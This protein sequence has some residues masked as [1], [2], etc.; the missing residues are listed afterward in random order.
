ML[1]LSGLNKPQLQAVKHGDTPLMV[2]AG[3]GAGK[4]RVLTHRV[5][6][7]IKK[8][9]H[10][11]S[12]LFVS[13]FTNAAAEEMS[14]RLSKMIGQHS[15]DRLRIGTFHSLCR[16]ILFDCLEETDDNFEA[17][18]LLRGG[19]RFFTMQGLIRSNKL[20]GIHAK[21][22]LKLIGLWKNR[23]V[24]VKDLLA[25][26]GTYVPVAVRAYQL[27]QEHL[28]EANAYDFDDMLFRTYWVL[29][30]KRSK[31]F[32]EKLRSRIDHILLDEAQD[33]A[34]IQYMIMRL[35]SEG[36]RH[37]TV[38]GD[39]WQAIFGFRGADVESVFGFVKEYSATIV[40]LEENYRSTQVIVAASNRLIKHNLKQLPKTLFTSN[41]AGKPIEIIVGH[42]A[43]DEAENVFNRINSLLV[44][45]GYELKDIAILYRTNAQ[46]RAIVDILIRNCIPHRV[47][48]NYGFYDRAEVKDMVSYL[49][50][51]TNPNDA[52]I[53]DFR[54][55]INKPTRYLGKKFIDQVESLQIDNDMPT[56]WEAFQHV[57]DLDIGPFQRQHAVELVRV[58][59]TV[60]QWIVDAQPNTGEIFQRV[61]T[62][63]KYEAWLKKEDS[64]E[65][66][67]DDSKELNIESLLA[68]AAR[69]P[70]AEDFLRFIDSIGDAYDEGDDYISLMSCHKAKGQE[71][72]VV[73]VLGVS[74]KL[75]PH[76]KAEDHDEERR[77]FFVA[78]TRPMECLIISAIQGKYNRLNVSPSRYIREM[79]LVI[80]ETFG[81]GQT[82]N[83]TPPCAEPQ[84]QQF[85]LQMGNAKLLDTKGDEIVL[86]PFPGSH[87]AELLESH[88]D[89]LLDEPGPAVTMGDL[90]NI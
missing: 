84:Q 24:R 43:D 19:G 33:T 17:P 10:L 5:A 83:Y 62:E 81:D 77:V 18:T 25:K 31:K 2:S 70:S 20:E 9:G 49:R 6:Y 73:F 75:M 88:S 67:P 30:K 55:I 66:Q 3:P 68:G 45:D 85:S 65:D 47:F 50:I 57:D 46:S 35:L 72:P 12:R 74:E 82:L 7:L 89:E 32:L 71:F 36:K 16:R 42:E 8:C 13:T 11:P 1:D 59:N 39:D 34:P 58:I 37:V 15:V 64:D 90:E 26:S 54:R 80:P 40:K 22:A 79:G 44:D 38:V 63:I 23:G 69:F 51:V 41:V 48:A 27:Y 86:K 56:F 29:Q 61:L 76:F 53:T 21:E 4:T 60:S 14:E 87:A 78:V 28:Y 52:D